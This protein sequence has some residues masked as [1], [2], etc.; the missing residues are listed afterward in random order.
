MY[1]SLRLRSVRDTPYTSYFIETQTN[2]DI[3]FRKVHTSKDILISSA[4]ICCGIALFFFNKA[5]GIIIVL[6]GLL[7][8]IFYKGAYKYGDCVFY[9]KAADISTTSRDSL[10]AFLQGG[11]AT[12]VLKDANCGASLRVEAYFSKSH[13]KAY[14]QVYD[15]LNYSYIPS[16]EMVLL[17]G[18]RA[19]DFE[20]ILIALR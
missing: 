13:D 3:K 9:K 8:L 1:A 11:A 10:M 17:E 15:F 2:M 19:G 20:K 7:L 12:P 16:G 4:V 14:V 5:L 6:C 18:D